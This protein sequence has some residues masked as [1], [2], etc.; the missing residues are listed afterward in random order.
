M[1][2]IAQTALARGKAGEA[3]RGVEM[4]QTKNGG[5]PQ[6]SKRAGKSV[7]SAERNSMQRLRRD[8]GEQKDSAAQGDEQ[9]TV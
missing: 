1:V 6:G 5:V 8:E 7:A 4:D 2:Y 9:A 3:Q